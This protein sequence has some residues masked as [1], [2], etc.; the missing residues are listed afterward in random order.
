MYILWAV[1]SLGVIVGVAV[2]DS[3]VFVLC[4]VSVGGVSGVSVGGV[5]GVSVGVGG[6]VVSVGVGGGESGVLVSVG[7][8]VG[9]G[10]SWT[11]V[12]VRLPVYFR[13]MATSAPI[14][15]TASRIAMYLFCACFI[16]CVSNATVVLFPTRLRLPMILVRLPCVVWS[17]A[18][19]LC[20]Y[21]RYKVS[22]KVV[23]GQT[24][25]D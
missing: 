7:S 13:V 24:E 11:A 8:G 6:S 16:D 20:F 23:R 17:G 5:S 3:G 4:G 12:P 18:D 2:G 21:S 19:G 14:R 9:R 1:V 25:D 22:K 15:R 10:E